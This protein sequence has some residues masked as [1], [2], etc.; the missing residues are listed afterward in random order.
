MK[1]KMHRVI[2]F[3]LVFVMTFTSLPTMQI[4]ANNSNDVTHTLKVGGTLTLDG[5]TL[6]VKDA[7]NELKNTIEK[8]IIEINELINGLNDK[9]SN[10]NSDIRE[11]KRQIA[12]HELEIDVCEF[13]S[14][15][16]NSEKIKNL[17]EKIKIL[18]ENIDKL[19]DQK[20]EVFK[21]IENKYKEIET[22]I[23]ELNAVLIDLNKAAIEGVDFNDLSIGTIIKNIAIIANNIDEL[24]DDSSEITTNITMQEK[25]ETDVVSIN[26]NIVTAENVGVAVIEAS[27]VGKVSGHVYKKDTYVIKVNYNVE[28]LEIKELDGSLNPGDSVNL[29]LNIKSELNIDP[30][31]FV[32]KTSDEDIITVDENGKVTAHKEGTAKVTVTLKNS[33]V[34]AEIEIVVL[35]TKFIVTFYENEEVLK[36]I[37]VELNDTL[38]EDTLEDVQDM[39][40]IE[41]GYAFEKWIDEDGNDVTFEN[42]QNDMN[43]YAKLRKLEYIRLNHVLWFDAWVDTIARETV[44]K[45]PG[46]DYNDPQAVT[47]A[48]E[49]YLLDENVA[50]EIGGKECVGKAT[51]STPVVYDAKRGQLIAKYGVKRIIIKSAL[52]AEKKNNIKAVWKNAVEFPT[53]TEEASLYEEFFKE[54]DADVDKEGKRYSR[55]DETV[56][57]VSANNVI[58][59]LNYRELPSYE[60]TLVDQDEN[61]IEK[62]NVFEGYTLS[63][64]NEVN[65]IE[66]GNTL[67]Y[68][69]EVE[70][71][72]FEKWL[73][74]N[75]NE[76]DIEN[77][78][79]NSNRTFK[80]QM[81]K[82]SNMYTVKF[83]VLD[84]YKLKNG[85]EEILER[86]EYGTIDEEFISQLV[87]ELGNKKFDNLVFTLAED[88]K[89][90]NGNVVSAGEEFTTLT[91]NENDEVVSVMTD[92]AKTY[93]FARNEV[94]TL[95][96]TVSDK[97]LVRHAIE[98]Y[99]NKSYGGYFY[100]DEANNENVFVTREEIQNN[101]KAYVY[102]ESIH[103]LKHA[104]GKVENKKIKTTDDTVLLVYWGKQLTVNYV[105]LD[106][107]GNEKVIKEKSEKIYPFEDG[108][109]TKNTTYE[110]LKESYLKDD[111]KNIPSNEDGKVYVF[112]GDVRVEISKKES[113]S[114]CYNVANITL[115]FK[116]Q[117]ENPIYLKHILFFNDNSYKYEEQIGDIQVVARIE[118]NE[119]DVKAENYEMYALDGYTLDAKWSKDQKIVLSYD[120]V[121]KDGKMD[122]LL[123]F[124]YWAKRIQIDYVGYDENDNLVENFNDSFVKYINYNEFDKIAEEKGLVITNGEGAWVADSEI[125]KEIVLAYVEENDYANSITL[126]NGNEYACNDKT[127]EITKYN[128]AI[129]TLTYNY[130]EI[131]NC[132][133]DCDEKIE[134][135]QKNDEKHNKKYICDDCLK[136]KEVKSENHDYGNDN[137]CDLCDYVRKPLYT[138]NSKRMMPVGVYKLVNSEQKI[139]REFVDKIAE[140]VAEELSQN[141]MDYHNDSNVEIDDEK[142]YELIMSNLDNATYYETET[143][144][145]YKLS[146]LFYY[147]IQQQIDITLKI[148]DA[149]R[150]T[151]RVS[152]SAKLDKVEKE[153]VKAAKELFKDQKNEKYE[154]SE[155]PELKDDKYSNITVKLY[156]EDGTE[157]YA[158]GDVLFKNKNR[159]NI[160]RV[161]EVNNDDEELVSMEGENVAQGLNVPM[162]RGQFATELLKAY[163]IEPTS[164]L[165]KNFNDVKG[166]VNEEAILRLAT[167]Y[168]YQGYGQTDN[169]GPND[170]LTK[171][172]MLLILSRAIIY[173]TNKLGINNDLTEE[174]IMKSLEEIVDKEEISSWAKAGVSV[175]IDKKLEENK[176]VDPKKAVTYDEAIKYINKFLTIVKENDDKED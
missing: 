174:E 170:I 111:I 95:N 88:A 68:S 157:F 110:D 148:N 54:F 96:V 8:D 94:V 62:Y 60:V 29:E 22:N 59:T 13:E 107:N 151:T 176:K 135:T 25:P 90:V 45:I 152:K 55:T 39:L 27:M 2:A 142:I 19:E 74:E 63:N 154:I 103:Y 49:K 163:P 67:N 7:I 1:K 73:D 20:K 76:C 172:Q 108:E 106:E 129:V 158:I 101:A 162:T 127:C 143:E 46:I 3:L 70:E 123:T 132:E 102:D 47:A 40:D 85:S 138:V 139:T 12:I 118:E 161:A 80:A 125:S 30:S 164:K 175:A 61:V 52:D 17:E 128:Q 109:L 173:S 144:K 5:Y 92:N 37:P 86:Q 91:V 165:R 147:N 104:Y 120:D 66:I 33:D 166:N 24:K 75:S 117:V 146:L 11:K 32:W 82:T 168:I 44:E 89:L 169:I 31:E 155:I 79:I 171:E 23:D 114:A 21:T 119:T 87:L 131:A 133:H 53:L 145:G 38:S 15:K 42:I 116:E 14:W 48:Y 113:Y 18:E 105:E 57:L 51:T 43:V 64:D 84:G 130:D 16:D 56:T 9:I 140:E 156:A 78:I 71:A 81:T 141:E 122:T 126:A 4:Y 134:Y 112:T 41:D 65:A 167:E 28:S 99:S 149:P 34:S 26:G 93:T 160:N 100:I 50:R 77:E 36:Q 35:K 150:F 10:I 97:L 69:N 58:I 124:K 153:A 136:L 83:N 6:K 98:W 159:K 72:K 115:I 121:N 137:I